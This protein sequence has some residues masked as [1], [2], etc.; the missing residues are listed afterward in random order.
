M[1]HLPKDHLLRQCVKYE[2]RAMAHHIADCD[3]DIELRYE[4]WEECYAYTCIRDAI[5]YPGR[6]AEPTLKQWLDI[7]LQVLNSQPPKWPCVWTLSL[8]LGWTREWLWPTVY[9]KEVASTC[10]GVLSTLE[11]PCEKSNY[12]PGGTTWSDL[13]PHGKG[14]RP[15]HPHA[16]AELRIHSPSKIP[17]T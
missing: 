7:C 5:R 15:S 13:T 6:V 12:P 1:N 11:L 4:A 14:E 16:S 2:R 9:K 8:T 10:L 3:W 17:D